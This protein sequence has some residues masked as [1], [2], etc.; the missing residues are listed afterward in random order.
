MAE[1]RAMDDTEPA[2]EATAKVDP[3]FQRDFACSEESSWMPSEGP[4]PRPKM[5]AAGP[6]KKPENHHL[7]ARFRPQ[8]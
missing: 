4:Y 1:V 7:G 6:E 8:K 5:S 3:Q 2:T